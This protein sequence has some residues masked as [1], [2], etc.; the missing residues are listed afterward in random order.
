MLT[1]SQAERVLTDS[2]TALVVAEDR[3]RAAH[4]E[5][6]IPSRKTLTLEGPKRRHAGAL[7]AGFDA[8]RATSIHQ[9][10]NGNGHVAVGGPL[11]LT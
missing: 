7:E 8:G 3:A 9:P 6:L 10:L 2:Q 11:L 5:D 4:L 1:R